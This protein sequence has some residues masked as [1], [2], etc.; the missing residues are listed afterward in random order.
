[1]NKKFIHLVYAIT[2]LSGSAVLAEQIK[3]ELIMP[4]D[5]SWKGTIVN[6]DGDWIEFMTGETAKPIRI[7]AST[8]KELVFAV[9]LDAEKL[10]EMNRNREYER[11]IAAVER[12]LVPYAPFNDI[13]SNLTKY[14][15]LLMEL[16]YKTGAYDKS[17]ALAAEISKDARDPVLQEKSKVFQALTM[18]DAGR[19][20]EAA[21]LLVQYGWD[22]EISEDATPEKLYIT[23]KLLFLKKQYNVAMELAAKVVAFHSQNAEWLQPAELLCA[24]IYAELGLYESADEVIREIAMLYKD[25]AENDQAQQLKLK[26]E[27]SRAEKQLTENVGSEEA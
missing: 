22:K 9:D 11:I 4:G 19:A 17:L 24:Q 25:T 14:K 16:Y 18:I 10:N 13:P 3:V 2:C 5:K 26:I 23:A 27:K 12:T 1:M 21:A 7:G 15:A 20:D 6:R 8:I